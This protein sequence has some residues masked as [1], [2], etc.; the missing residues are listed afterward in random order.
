M[1]GYPREEDRCQGC[2]TESRWGEEPNDCMYSC[3]QAAWLWHRSVNCAMNSSAQSL[4]QLKT[5]SHHPGGAGDQGVVEFW[6]CFAFVSQMNKWGQNNCVQSFFWEFKAKVAFE[7]GGFA[8]RRCWKELKT[9]LGLSWGVFGLLQDNTECFSSCPDFL[10]A[11]LFFFVFFSTRCIGGTN[12]TEPEP[13]SAFL[14]VSACL[15]CPPP[16]STPTPLLSTSSLCYRHSGWR[17]RDL[18]V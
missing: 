8:W 5:A 15:I 9:H 14:H 16:P 12:R 2:L 17:F 4:H 11:F 18:K 1:S 3:S 7:L 10:D 6:K 13:D